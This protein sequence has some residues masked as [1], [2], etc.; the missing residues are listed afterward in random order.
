[1][2]KPHI[3]LNISDQ[4]P[5][6][7]TDKIISNLKTDGLKLL[8]N[9]MPNEPYASIEW[10]I[11]GLIAVFIAQSYFGSFLGE[12]GKDH[13]S[14]LKNWLKKT[15]VDS[16]S[17]KVKT[18]TANKS[19][20]KLDVKNSQSNAFSIGFETMDNKHIKLLFDLDLE[21]EIWR[22]SI[23]DIIEMV[24]KNH[25]NYPNDELTKKISAFK[26]ERK[27]IYAFIDNNNE[28]YFFENIRLGMQKKRNDKI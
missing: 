4:F 19:T 6:I 23:D 14:T 26:S 9:K 18:V 11:P 1:M 13:Y 16:K 7:V 21:D 28:W 25:E 10:A 27:M 3:I 12:L 22:K 15:A 17:I 8:I 20:K 5:E 24:K 2:D